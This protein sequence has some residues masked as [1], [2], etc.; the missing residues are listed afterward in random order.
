ME[1]LS[2]KPIDIAVLDTKTKFVYGSGCLFELTKWIIFTVVA[3]I[4]VHFFLATIF[5]VDGLSMYPNFSGGEYILANRWQYNFGE[6]QRGDVVILRFPG[7]PE[8]KKYIKR[9][10]GLPNDILTITKGE[11]YINN[12]KLNEPYLASGIATD[13]DINIKLGADEYF[14]IGDNR[15]NSSDSRTWGV[16]ARRFLIGRAW[17]EFYPKLKVIP[18]AKY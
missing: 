16:A 11:V 17:V 7:D 4:L 14:L 2:T 10:V 18:Q 1:N 13:Q 8:H 15:P 12:R 6:P 3:V 9:L 5:V